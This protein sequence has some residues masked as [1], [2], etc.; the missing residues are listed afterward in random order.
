MLEY[1]EV[2]TGVPIESENLVEFHL[3]YSGLL[4]SAG[5]ENPR[6]EKHAIRRVFHSQLRRLWETNT[7]LRE[8]AVGNG[9]QVR[10]SGIVP[11]GLSEEWFEHG[12]RSMGAN[13]NRAGFN[14]LPLVTKKVCLRCSLDILFLRMDEYPFV[15]GSSGDI[16][17]RLKT[18][19]D[20]LRM[21]DAGELPVGAKP[22]QGEDP[23]FVLLEDDKL[24]SEVRVNTDRLL[25]LPEAKVPDKHDVYLQISVKL[26]TTVRTSYS[27]VFD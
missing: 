20:S 26:N 3:L 17:G 10:S 8:L 5:Q 9:Q 19:V 21:A 27:W 23:L 12:A 7:Y 4:H 2:G 1:M 13:W 16:D 18:L 11:E 22:E 15:F 6:K 24:I 14:F 25:K